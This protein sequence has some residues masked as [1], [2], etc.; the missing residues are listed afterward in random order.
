MFGRGSCAKSEVGC[1]PERPIRERARPEDARSCHPLGPRHRGHHVDRQFAVNWLDRNLQK[2]P[3]KGPLSEGEI[4][5]L[6]SGAFYQVEKKLLAPGEMP[7]VLHSFKWQNFT[8]W[9]SGIGLLIVVYYMSG[10]SLLV[11]PS[12]SSLHPHAIKTIGLGSII[13]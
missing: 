10:G 12:I 6:H 11:D 2:V 5:L 8:T 4:W 9:A 13:G 7:A 3:G 1:A